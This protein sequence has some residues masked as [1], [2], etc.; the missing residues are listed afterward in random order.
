MKRLA[1]AL[2]A[3]TALPALGAARIEA[4]AVKPAPA[5]VASR[6]TI[7]LS[8]NRPTPLDL[9]PCDIAIDPGD[10]EK[11]LQ[12]TF[13][14]GDGHMKEVRYT[15]RKVGTYKVMA[16]GAG[17][18]ACEGERAVEVKVGFS[19]AASASP[20]KARC[21]QG[22][23]VASQDGPRYTCRADA[24][25]RPIRCEGGTKYFSESGLIGCR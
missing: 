23:S 5:S 24:P 14:P 9:A 13:G 8:M 18:H 1:A 15:Y 19:G 22:W 3:A 7:S 11:G 25:S 4:I 6:V 21:P 20:E 16:R 10:G 12:V 17:K 2:V